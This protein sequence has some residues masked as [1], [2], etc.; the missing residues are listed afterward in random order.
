MF[1]TDIV[2]CDSDISIGCD[3]PLTIF[4]K[5]LRVLSSA[6][7][8]FSVARDTPLTLFQKI[9]RVLS[10]ARH[11]F[12]VA[13]HT[14]LTLFQKIL[15]VLSS[16]RHF[17]SVARHTIIVCKL[18][19]KRGG[20]D[21]PIWTFSTGLP[22]YIVWLSSCVRPPAKCRYSAASC[23]HHARSVLAPQPQHCAATT[24]SSA[25]CVT[26]IN[27]CHSKLTASSF[28]PG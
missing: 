20:E 16:V 6:R 19:L 1:V 24:A 14:P 25:V 3:T 5:I 17:F 23:L 22:V 13:R 27:P 15:R 9:L 26:P 18:S 10:S 11:F 2:H 21:N 8:F 28:A 7:H 12:S 4:Q